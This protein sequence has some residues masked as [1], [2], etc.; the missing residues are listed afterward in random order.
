MMPVPAYM[1]SRPRFYQHDSPGVSPG[2]HFREGL[3]VLKTLASWIGSI[4]CI[5]ALRAVTSG[6]FWAPHPRNQLQ[7]SRLCQTRLGVLP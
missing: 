1:T 3:P 7:G 5:H 4:R 6:V 2:I